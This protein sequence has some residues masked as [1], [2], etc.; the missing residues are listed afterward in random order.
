MSEYGLFWNSRGGDRRYS[1]DSM[2]E[3][4][5]PFFS[6]GVFDSQ[7]QVQSDGGMKIKV[8]TGYCNIKGKV[9]WFESDSYFTLPIASGL[10]DRV[11]T[12]VVERNDGDRDISIKVIAGGS[13]GKPTPPVRESGIYQLV[14][15]QIAVTQ[16]ATSISQSDI[17]DTRMSSTLCGWVTSTIDEINF[18]QSVEQFTT[19]FNEYKEEII[20]EFDDAGDIAQAIFNAWFEHMKGQLSTDAA[21]NLQ[22]ELDNQADMVAEDYSVAKLYDIGAYVTH[23]NKLY[24]C[25]RTVTSYGNFN[26]NFW[27]EVRVMDQVSTLKFN[28]DVGE[29]CTT[30]FYSD[31]SILQTYSDRK[32]QTLFNSDGSITEKLMT[33]NNDLIATKTTVFNSDNSITETVVKA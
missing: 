14:L 17:T 9:R 21:G 27:T 28:D 15:A 11:D 8:G 22:I 20:H 30:V 3:W 32:K 2:E 33:L 13:D 4:L 26:P 24:R 31:G 18:D 5:N 6:T 16:G 10:Y 12:V 25:I 29:N 7:L 19:W 1:A 23:E